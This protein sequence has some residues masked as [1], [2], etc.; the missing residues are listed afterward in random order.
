MAVVT[1]S[2]DSDRTVACSRYSKVKACDSAVIHSYF[3]LVV[4][5]GSMN[6]ACAK[7]LNNY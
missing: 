6:G 5:A 3:P 2:P 4:R 7:I 1:S